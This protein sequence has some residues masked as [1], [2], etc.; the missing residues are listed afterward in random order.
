MSYL[1]IDLGTSGL[2]ALLI[3]EDGV[4]IG[5]AERRY[6]ASH[7]Q[8]GW[9]EQDPADWITALE[10]A[11]ERKLKAGLTAGDETVARIFD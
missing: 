8:P 5:G 6:G 7:P 9:S 11:I 3:D 10:D 4:A 2:R 1:G